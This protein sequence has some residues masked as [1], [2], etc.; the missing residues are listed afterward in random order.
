MNR[1]PKLA[2]GTSSAIELEYP[3][4]TGTKGELAEVPKAM[5]QEKV[6]LAEAPC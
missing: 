4:P 5:G 1:V 3:A 6:E 2:E